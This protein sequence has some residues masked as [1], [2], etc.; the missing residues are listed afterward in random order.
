MDLGQRCELLVGLGEAQSRDGDPRALETFQQAVALARKQKEVRILGRAIIGLAA[1][2]HKPGFA[3]YE[4][5]DALDQSLA[6]LEDSHSDLKARTLAQLSLE[7]FWSDDRDRAISSG[8][9][10]VETARQAGSPSALVWTLWN[11]HLV[12]WGPGNLDDRLSTANEIVHLAE[13]NRDWD[14]AITGYEFRIGALLEGGRID[15]VERAIEAC[16]RLVERTGIPSASPSRFRCMFAMLRGDLERAEVELQNLQAVA[17]RRRD[18]TLQITFAGQF[19]QLRGEQGRLDELESLLKNAAQAFPGFVTTRCGLALL[20]ARA[21]RTTDATVEFEYLAAEGFS[22]IRKD[23]NWLGTMALLS[24]VAATLGDTPR[25]EALY[26]LLQPYA[27]RIVTLGFGDVCYGPVDHYLGLLAAAR[28]EWGIAEHHFKESIAISLRMSARPLL[29]RTQLH[30]AEMLLSRGE[31]S[32]VTRSR[33]LLDSAGQLAERLGM[34]EI[35]RKV[36]E[37]TLNLDRSRGKVRLP[38]REMTPSVTLDRGDGSVLATLLFIDIAAST[39]RAVAMGDRQW[40]EKLAEYY[41]IVREKLEQF[42]GR[43]VNIAGDGFLVEL[44]S[45]ARAVRCATDV[46]AAAR[47]SSIETRVG[48]HIG[49]CRIIGNDLTGVAVHVGARVASLAKAGEIIVS[50]TVR[51]LL[52]GSDFVFQDRGLQTLKGLPEQW[53]IFLVQAK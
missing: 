46:Q 12:L 37:R 45:P 21:G 38:S 3:D 50:S 32:D 20:Y 10:A 28:R 8:R 15:D 53:R 17:H 2:S 30:Y 22:R 47:E 4:L 48:I 33:D 35:V 7:L 19:G 31:P 34:A 49:E 52:V 16:S 27:G 42:G 11:L 39:E 14:Q 24:E 43:E 25:S 18:P 26:A 40:A 1:A 9:L 36:R 51:D 44:D 23:W 41:R 13:Q 29:A 6:A 5:I